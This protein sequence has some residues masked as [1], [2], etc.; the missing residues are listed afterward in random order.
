MKIE[1]IRFFAGFALALICLS[2]II[3]N[4][5]PLIAAYNA[6]VELLKSALTLQNRQVGGDKPP[7]VIHIAQT[8]QE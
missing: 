1:K 6:D 2:F 3:K 7:N 8:M 4:S 5:K